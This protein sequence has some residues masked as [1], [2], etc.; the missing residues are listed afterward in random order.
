MTPNRTSRWFGSPPKIDAATVRS[1]EID[2]Q[3]TKERVTIRSRRF[4]PLFGAPG[5]GRSTFLR[6]A[7]LHGSGYNAQE[8]EELGISIQTSMISTL[9]LILGS[10]SIS[11]DPAVQL[12]LSSQEDQLILADTIQQLLAVPLMKGVIEASPQF[13]TDSSLQY[14]MG[15]I[16]RIITSRYTPT[17]IDLL[18]CKFPPAPPIV[19][20]PFNPPGPWNG[21]PRQTTLV[22][23]R[24]DIGLQRKWLTLFGEAEAIIFLVDLSRYDQT[25][26]FSETEEELNCIRA[27]MREF[28]SI[29]NVPFMYFDSAASALFR[30]SSHI[31][32]FNKF[33]LFTEKL[34]RIPFTACFPDYTGPNEPAAAVEYCTQR[35]QALYGVFGVRQRNIRTWCTNCLD[36]DQMGVTL[37]EIMQ[38]I[39][40]R[41]LHVVREAW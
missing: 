1:N 9:R 5:A 3:L 27:A 8:R 14:M 18:R 24:R 25:E 32:V 37:Q 28:E 26:C 29:C 22:S 17:D 40:R 34:T 38:S 39:F 21:S 12:A 35:F 23:V 13:Q 2:K 15:L 36:V 31:V 41:R 6:Q 11:D 7:K 20:I 33:D 4:L 19:E 30:I 16:P 10:A